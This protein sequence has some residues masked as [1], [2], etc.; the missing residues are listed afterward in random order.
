MKEPGLDG[1]HRDKK[2]GAIRQKRSDATL[3]DLAGRALPESAR[4]RGA[5][6]STDP[7]KAKDF[8]ARAGIVDSKGKLTK[9][10]K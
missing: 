8:L 7:A 5:E 6:I 4:K 3:R 1:R 10:Y 2:A 9:R